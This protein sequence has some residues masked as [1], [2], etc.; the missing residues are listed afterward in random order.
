MKRSLGK[1][2]TEL[3]PAV[4]IAGLLLVCG[5]TKEKAEAIK[6]AAEQFR[7]EAVAALAE[8]KSLFRESLG[9]PV[10]SRE[11]LTARF[12]KD[13]E[14]TTPFN[15]DELSALLQ[16]PALGTAA[17]QRGDEQFNKLEARYIEFAA[18]FRSL[19]QGSYFA[20]KSVKKAEKHAINLTLEMINFAAYLEKNPVR[21][22]AR[23]VLL[24]E[25]IQKDKAAADP[26]VRATLLKK[27]A[28]VAL[29]L[30]QDELAARQRAIEAC[31]QAAESCRTVAELIRNYDKM[32]ASDI[33]AM[34]REALSFTAEV[35]GGNLQ[36]TALLDKYK[37]VEAGI[38][39]DPYWNPLLD[40][41]INP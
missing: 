14:E 28:E 1:L 36:V 23:R 26:T 3:L 6:I 13:V 27:D 21:F 4:L 2:K 22:T 16:D 31:L 24:L 35:S 37:G 7:A 34:T 25:S 40:K 39:S 10:E 33:L 19:P 12:V 30:Q 17:L 20:A 11:E 15:S 38:R 5:C 8:I 41:P 18:M 29:Q 9:V 32:S